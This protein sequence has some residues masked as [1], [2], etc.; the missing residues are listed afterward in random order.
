MKNIKKITLALSLALFGG[1][2][3]ADVYT[4]AGFTRMDFSYEVAD[5]KWDG[6]VSSLTTT[7]GYK[8]SDYFSLEASIYSPLEKIETRIQIDTEKRINAEQTD[9]DDFST[10]YADSFDVRYM[11]NI[12]LK[13]SYP[14]NDNFS[15]YTDL[16][17][18][19]LKYKMES[20]DTF[21]DNLGSGESIAYDILD[22]C[23]ITG[24]ES[25][26]FCNNSVGVKNLTDGLLSG[27]TYG[28]GFAF[29]YDDNTDLRF[30]YKISDFKNDYTL[31]E[32]GI[33]FRYL[34]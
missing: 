29:E 13:L 18:S 1:N 10:E 3:M 16:G 8:F 2:A 31:S 25:E 17:Y 28:V 24:R 5:S 34:F 4:E 23:E 7:L 22:A 30:S 27:V 14:I 20:Y 9:F 15:I 12:S 21:T 11:G 32:I 19:S 33:K 26:N 6:G